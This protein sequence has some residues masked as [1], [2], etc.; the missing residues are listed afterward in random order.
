VKGRE[1]VVLITVIKRANKIQAR[2]IEIA[3]R[4]MKEVQEQ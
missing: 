4:R 2:L 1:M 3:R